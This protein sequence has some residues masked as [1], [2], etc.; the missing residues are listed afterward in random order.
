MSLAST[1]AISADSEGN[2]T[3]SP[4]FG[5]TIDGLKTDESTIDNKQLDPT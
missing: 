5:G 1:A 2:S 3:A 4:Q